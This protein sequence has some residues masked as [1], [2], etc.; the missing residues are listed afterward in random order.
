MLQQHNLPGYADGQLD[1]THRDLNNIHRGER[2]KLL[3][4]CQ[5]AT[6]NWPTMGLQH[7]TGGDNSGPAMGPMHTAD[8]HLQV[9]TTKV[10]L[11][12]ND[13]IGLRGHIHGP[14]SC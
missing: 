2:H 11:T 4:S 1:V 6:Y 5:T 12:F 3:P 9:K 14:T 10:Q 7:A 13:T 8:R